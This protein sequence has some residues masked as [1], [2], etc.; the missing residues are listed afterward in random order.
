[1]GRRDWDQVLSSLWYVDKD[2]THSLTNARQAKTFTIPRWFQRWTIWTQLGMDNEAKIL[3]PE[4]NGIHRV[5][6]GHTRWKFGLKFSCQSSSRLLASKISWSKHVS[7][8]LSP[9]L[10]QGF[11]SIPEHSVVG[12]PKARELPRKTDP[13]RTCTPAVLQWKGPYPWSF[14]ICR[15][16][17]LVEAMKHNTLL[18]LKCLSSSLRRLKTLIPFL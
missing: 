10:H 12:F 15:S 8:R 2:D 1:M 17:G 11:S 5:S 16:F 7:L 3:L 13:Q 18:A 6:N 14:E 4:S 9:S